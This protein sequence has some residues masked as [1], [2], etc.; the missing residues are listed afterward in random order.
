[1]RRWVAPATLLPTLLA[2]TVPGVP[3]AHASPA[4]ALSGRRPA[5]SALQRVTGGRYVALGDSFTAGPL[6]PRHRG[7]PFE[8]I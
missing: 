5:V 3:A 7:K 8:V 1:M 6:I 4:H 2:A